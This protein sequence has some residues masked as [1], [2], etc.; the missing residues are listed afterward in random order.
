MHDRPMFH[1]QTASLKSDLTYEYRAEIKLNCSLKL[2]MLLLHL[3]CGLNC[4]VK[5]Y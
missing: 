1:K 3:P 4:S 2:K 5:P